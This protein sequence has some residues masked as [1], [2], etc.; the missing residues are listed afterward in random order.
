MEILF[1]SVPNAR[2]SLDTSK[3]LVYKL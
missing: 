1:Q 2:S 3:G